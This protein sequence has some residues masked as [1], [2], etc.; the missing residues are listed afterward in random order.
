MDP[1]LTAYSEIFQEDLVPGIENKL[2]Q[3]DPCYAKVVTSSE[4]VVQDEIT[5][6]YKV[7]HTFCR[8]LAGAIRAGS[9][10]GPSMLDNT[11]A[12]KLISAHDTYPGISDIPLPGTARR[13]ITLGKLR[14][15]LTLPLA[16]LRGAKLR[17]VDDMPALIL[18]QSAQMVAHTMAVNWFL[19]DSAQAVELDL[20]G[21]GAT[22]SQS[23]HVV[24]MTGPTALNVIASGR[25]RRIHPGLQYDC[26]LSDSTMS[27]C[28]TNNGWAMITSNVDMYDPS[29][30]TLYFQSETDATAFVL[31]ADPNSDGTPTQDMF[32]VPYSAIP[33]RSSAGLNG[34]IFPCG[35]QWWLRK[36]GTLFG[37]FGD[38]DVTT[39]GSMFK[40]MVEAS[41]AA[42]TE[43]ILNKYLA[44][45]EEATGVELDTIVLTHGILTNMLA[46]YGA[47]TATA[48]TL[49]RV[50]RDE[51]SAQ[52]T[53][54]G[55]DQLLYVFNGRKLDINVSAFIN[56]GEVAIMKAN[57]GNLIRY[58]PPKVD[59]T[60]A[61]PG[62]FDPGI[63]WLGKVFYDGIWMPSTAAGGGKTDG[64]E[65]PFDLLTQHAVVEPRGIKL[66]GVT[67]T[68]A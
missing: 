60:D 13:Y 24:T 34:S 59:G 28:Y 35:Y 19:N 7:L 1:I 67:E 3:I 68:T 2:T 17:T 51:R 47:D 58:R 38:L 45:F 49:V 50:N 9:P 65:A 22:I 29:S 57:N 32:L 61:N 25:Y 5:K 41:A 40:S 27:A 64:M 44:T 43:S 30:L 31:A 6:D 33:D 26:W 23:G 10:L 63:E 48:N 11:G 4:R 37:S 62:G 46:T 39:Y 18:Q 14:G 16:L 53:K 21:S 52:G 20:S 54:L 56:S 42:L 15:N 8:S 12:T 36:T 66:I 55:W